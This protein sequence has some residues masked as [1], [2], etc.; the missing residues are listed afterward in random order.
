MSVSVSE[1]HRPLGA[2]E[3]AT[4]GRDAGEPAAR[5]ENRWLS[6]AMVLLLAGAVVLQVF[7][8][9]TRHQFSALRPTAEWDRYIVG[10]YNPARHFDEFRPNGYIHTVHLTTFRLL[11]DSLAAC[12]LFNLIL[13]VVTAALGWLLLRRHTAVFVAFSLGMVSPRMLESAMAA[14]PDQAGTCVVFLVWMLGL[15]HASAG[16]WRRYG[17]LA[18]AAVLTVWGS[19]L[20]MQGTVVLLASVLSLGVTLGVLRWRR[21]ELFSRLPVGRLCS[22]AAVVGLCGAASHLMFKTPG[23]W[24]NIVLGVHARWNNRVWPDIGSLFRPGFPATFKDFLAHPDAPLGVVHNWFFNF[25]S[26]LLRHLFSWP[27]E[28]TEFTYPPLLSLLLG[29]CLAAVWVRLYRLTRGDRQA[30][31]RWTVFV[32]LL[33]AHAISYA[34]WCLAFLM[35]RFTLYSLPLCIFFLVQ[36]VMMEKARIPRRT[37]LALCVVAC[38]VSLVEFGTHYR[39]R[40]HP[41][42]Q[43]YLSVPTLA[44][45]DP[46][47]DLWIEPRNGGEPFYYGAVFA[48]TAPPGVHAPERE[49]LFVPR[50]VARNL[51]QYVLRLKKNEQVLKEVELSSAPL[52]TL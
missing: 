25:Q 47:V 1:V 44:A 28:L 11:G 30:E 34:A 2:E 8:L 5:P 48:Y 22:Y 21:R 41:Y 42:S 12:K 29:V 26:N 36:Y 49:R 46:F 24:K 52:Q 31:A 18:A 43:L 27:F 15:A 23:N 14:A 40:L 50:V 32:A 33:G 6:R 35:D 45:P 17:L 13:Y 20:R 51:D 9:L 39:K 4:L 3:P 37:V 7:D 19:S 10:V 38:C 16:G